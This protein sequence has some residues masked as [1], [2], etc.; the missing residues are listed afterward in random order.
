M[1]LTFRFHWS[2]GF[3]S[4]EWRRKFSPRARQERK[5]VF[6]CRES[7]NSHLT[8]VTNY[9]KSKAPPV[10][11]PSRGGD[12]SVY[13]P[14]SRKQT[15]WDLMSDMKSQQSGRLVRAKEDWICSRWV[16]ERL[17]NERWKNIHAYYYF[18]FNNLQIY[19]N[20][21]QRYMDKAIK[22]CQINYFF[23]A[24]LIIFQFCIFYIFEFFFI[25]HLSIQKSDQQ[26]LLRPPVS[27]GSEIRLLSRTHWGWRSYHFPCALK[28]FLLP[29][30]LG[31]SE[32]V[33]AGIRSR[34]NCFPASH[35]AEQLLTSGQIF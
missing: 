6:H 9:P 10:C 32:C 8:S 12:W 5:R 13:F 3:L 34:C 18:F 26:F 20:M 25:V 14:T 1:T 19:L 22:H 31:C 2:K 27:T 11:Q 33:V 16:Q 35:S 29:S 17:S 23:K 24:I 28:G 21:N 7:F 4:S 30:S 15:T